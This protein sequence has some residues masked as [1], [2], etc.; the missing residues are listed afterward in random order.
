MQRVPHHVSRTTWSPTHARRSASSRHT[1]PSVTII[2]T[3]SAH[4]SRRSSG[5]SR[6][7][8]SCRAATGLAFTRSTPAA[9]AALTSLC[10]PYAT[11]VVFQKWRWPCLHCPSEGIAVDKQANDDVMHL[12]PFRKA[13]GLAGQAFYAR[14]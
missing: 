8:G 9:H 14:P 5:T 7:A 11:G 12:G 4:V 3:R 10:P 13:D 1:P 2:A 6:D